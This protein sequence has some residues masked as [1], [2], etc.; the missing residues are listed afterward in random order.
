M[1]TLLIRSF[2]VTGLWG[3]KDVRIVFQPDVNITIGP[4]GSGKTSLLNILRYVLRG[5][6]YALAEISFR[7]STIELGAVGS[8][9][10]R[11]VI[12]EVLDEGMR[13]QVDDK[14][15]EFPIHLRQSGRLIH[16]GQAHMPLQF[17][18]ELMRLRTELR[19]LVSTVW[20]PVSRRLP[21]SEDDE[22]HLRPDRETAIELG[23]DILQ[24]D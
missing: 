9:A 2:E 20:L 22:I 10:R 6:V 17:R 13:F 16:R 21:V 8:T 4:N 14:T 23:C 7:T 24:S 5:D 19:E 3:S 18:E 11:R 15:F 12:C 1:P